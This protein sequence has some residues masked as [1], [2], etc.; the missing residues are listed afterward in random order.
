MRNGFTLIELLVVIGMIGILASTA[1]VA[2]NPL[3]QFAQARNAERISNVNAI[4][5]A[6]GTRIADTGG[7][8]TDDTTCTQPLPAS[9]T[10]MGSGTGNY[11]IRP[12][13]VPVY[14]PELP[15]DPS[16]GNSS[17]TDDACA[18]GSYDT[19]YTIELRAADRI[20]VCAPHAV[21]DGMKDA[22]CVTR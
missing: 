6:I 21:D 4:V 10:D 11:D 14:I 15:F 8:F 16:A 3:H 22:Y 17:C 5:S 19:G 2:I 7:T 20:R 13:L 12:C 9:L 1:L 18:S